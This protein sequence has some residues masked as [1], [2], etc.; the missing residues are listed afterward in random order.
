MK[1]LLVCT[2]DVGVLLSIKSQF[3]LSGQVDERLHGGEV[4]DVSVTDLSEQRLQIPAHTHT[5]YFI[6]TR[7][8]STS[9]P[10]SIRNVTFLNFKT[11]LKVKVNP[12]F[13]RLSELLLDRTTRPPR[14]I[15]KSTVNINKH[16]CKST[17]LNLP[18]NQ[19]EEKYNALNFNNK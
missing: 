14:L 4:G 7:Y 11:M 1:G 3:V 16:F 17:P 2:R 18:P 8:R 9:V 15:F 10:E 5:K 13:R 12:I 6:I 19:R